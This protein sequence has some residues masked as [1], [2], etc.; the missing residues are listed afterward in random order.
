MSEENLIKKVESILFSIGKKVQIEEISRLCKEKDLEK[1]KQALESLKE[2]YKSE[3]SSLTIL[4]EGD[5]WKLTVKEAFIPYIKNIVTET[6]LTKTVMETLAVIAY[7]APV[8]QSEVIRIRTNKAYDHIA[9]LEN[10]GYISRTKQGRTKLVKLTQKFFDY[11][12]IPP[13]KLKSKF[14]NVEELEKTVEEKEKEVHELTTEFE[15]K[16]AIAKEREE[17][18]KEEQE[19]RMEQ[20]DKEIAE[21]QEIDLVDE[22][23]KKHELKQYDTLELV[24][25]EL[26]EPAKEHLGKLDVYKSKKPTAEKPVAKVEPAAAEAPEAVAEATLPKAEA[27]EQP[28]EGATPVEEE[29]PAKPSVV[30]VPAEEKEEPEPTRE[31]EEVEEKGYD[32]TKELPKEIKGE[33]LFKEGIPPEVQKAIEKRAEEILTGKT[34]EEAPEEEKAEP[35][36]AEEPELAAEGNLPKAETSEQPSEE[37]A[38]QAEEEKPAEKPIV[39]S[40][41]TEKETEEKEEKKKESKAEKTEEK[42]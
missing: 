24:K 36:P 10:A 28:E 2:K 31:I 21:M 12:D 6:D 42:E 23:G 33:R 26:P 19:K 1:I 4:Q 38:T 14:K 17:K 20:L 16:K 34:K 29:A 30:K 40:P 32:I 7:K 37:G 39:E 27:V 41:E 9:E 13:D 5:E 25:E 11:F 15:A 22:E 18:H 8:L 3:D 35:S